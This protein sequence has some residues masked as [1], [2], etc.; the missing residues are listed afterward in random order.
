MPRKRSDFNPG[1]YAF[2]GFASI[3]RS[4]GNPR[5]AG[6]YPSNREFGST[7]HRSVIDQWN[8]ESDWV[9]WRKGYEIYNRTAWSTLKIKNVNY[10]P[11]LDATGSNTPFV[12]ALLDATLYRNT[13]YQISNTFT[14]Y[15]YPTMKADTNTHYVVKRTPE[16]K[17]L[18][19]VTSIKNN[20]LVYT[21]NY[22]NGEVFVSIN[23]DTTTGRLLLQMVGER[24]ADGSYTDNNRTEATLKKILT[25]DTKPAIYTGRTLSD[26]LK[27]FV[28]LDQKPT[29]VR[30][31]IPVADVNVT[32][33]SGDFI[34][35]Q[36]VN[37][38]VKN[39][40]GSLDILSNPELLTNKIIYITDFFVDKPLSSMDSVTYK[41]DDYFFEVSIKENETSQPLV[42][43]DQGVNELPP[44]MLDLTGLP[45]IFTT[46]NASYTIEGSYVFKKASYQKYFGS[47]YLT[48]EVVQELV[49]DISYSI[50]P[51]II[52]K[53]D[54]V[55][56]E[57]IIESRPY[58][59][60][61]KLYPSLESGTQLVFTENSFAKTYTTDDK[62]T[63]IHTDVNPWMDEVFTSGLPLRPSVTY[64]CSCPNYSHT[65]LAMPQM[66]QDGTTRKINRQLRYPL[67]TALSPDEFDMIGQNKV[68]GKSASW[69]TDQHRLSFK[70]CKH[71]IASMFNDDLRV[72]EPNQY[73]VGSDNRNSNAL[74]NFNEKLVQEIINSANAYNLSYQ[75]TGISIS[76]IVFAM[77]NGL[78]LDPIETA[79]VVLDSTQ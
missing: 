78:N 13:P 37:N 12:D 49:H 5:A 57:L 45:T 54:I 15:E 75:R 58:F 77:S 55:N 10:D 68:A 25:A 70:L 35:N 42:G 73:P 66:S 20:S 8:L 4:L 34:P 7:V 47:Q 21:D 9:K 67:P 39:A 6:F 69:E 60:Q 1:V 40:E 72:R 26:E 62:W 74:E 18:G 27:N 31:T 17:S 19:T 38:Q 32:T 11:G 43:L 71:V 30:I 29:T 61:V 3:D 24:I 64:S 23:P 33:N 59:A 50:I 56:N 36:G 14:G 53:A 52:E 22:D 2:K 48:G 65:L 79:Y 76:E 51:F 44:S 63:D 41:D 28:N 46:A 16:N